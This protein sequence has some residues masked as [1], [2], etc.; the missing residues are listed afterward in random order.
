MPDKGHSKA[1]CALMSS[2]CATVGA[3]FKDQWLG[4]ASELYEIE[5]NT[6][7]KDLEYHDFDADELSAYYSQMGYKATQLKKSVVDH[8]PALYQ[9][10][11]FISDIRSPARRLP[12]VFT[13]LPP[14][15]AVPPSPPALH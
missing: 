9:T 8:P 3:M 13:H 1:V 14:L 12:C 10:L 15:R 11:A 6:R 2:G 4:G 7:L 5:F